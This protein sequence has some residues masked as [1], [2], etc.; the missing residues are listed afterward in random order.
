MENCPDARSGFNLVVCYYALGDTEK[1]KRAFLQL[2]AVPQYVC[3][4]N[5]FD[6]SC[7]VPA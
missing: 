4:G 5:W 3:R 7:V 6:L 1:M 2:V